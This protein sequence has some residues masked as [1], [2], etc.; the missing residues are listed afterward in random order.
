MVTQNENPAVEIIRVALLAS[1]NEKR[2]TSQ[3]LSNEDA[4]PI[5]LARAKHILR[6]IEKLK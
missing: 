4:P 1:Y 5:W 6:E 2:K 3:C